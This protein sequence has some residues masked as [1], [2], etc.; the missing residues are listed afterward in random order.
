[1]PDDNDRHRCAAAVASLI[2]RHGWRLLGERDWVESAL[3][4]LREGVASTPERAAFHAYCL[5]LHRACAGSQ[6]RSRQ[7]AGYRELFQLL[8]E[9]ARREQPEAAQELAQAAL[10]RVFEHF[11]RC[12][13]PGAFVAFALLQ[14]REAMRRHRREDGREQQLAS[15]EAWAEEGAVLADSRLEPLAALLGEEQRATLHRLIADYLRRHPRS[16]L[17]LVALLMEVV[18]GL[19]ERLVQQLR[20]QSSAQLAVLRSRARARLR[21]DN[22]WRAWAVELGVRLDERHDS[23][24]E[25]IRS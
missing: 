18:E 13:L 20:E 24:T 12:R 21:A 4:A 25:R 23:P 11:E 16:A 1:M 14:L 3:D 2:A 6:G 17:Q 7:E 5:A 15:V 22:D 19:D 10:E 9:R 8:H